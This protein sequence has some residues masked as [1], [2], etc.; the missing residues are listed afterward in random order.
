[1][2]QVLGHTSQC[3]IRVS[4]HTCINV[5]FTFGYIDSLI[6]FSDFDNVIISHKEQHQ[7][8]SNADFAWKLFML[9]KSKQVLEDND[10]NKNHANHKNNKHVNATNTDEAD[11]TSFAISCLFMVKSRFLHCGELIEIRK[12]YSI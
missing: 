5:F 12:K 7:E 2:Q 4:L 3:D 8:K 6:R 9:S 1:M 11:Y 10:S